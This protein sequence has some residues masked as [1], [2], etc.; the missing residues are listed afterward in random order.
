MGLKSGRRQRQGSKFFNYFIMKI[1]FM[2][3]KEIL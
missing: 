2:K 1:F 3:K